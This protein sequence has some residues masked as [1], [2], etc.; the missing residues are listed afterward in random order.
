MIA[1]IG[2]LTAGYI[3]KFERQFPY[4]IEEIWSVLTEN[5]KLKK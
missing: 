5:S 2:K 3:V 4:T 1:E